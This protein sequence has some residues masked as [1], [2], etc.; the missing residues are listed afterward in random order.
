MGAAIR[1]G[2][3]L[4]GANLISENRP[5]LRAPKLTV[6][7]DVSLEDG[8]TISGAVDLSSATV[9]GHLMLKYHVD[10]EHELSISDAHVQTLQLEILPAEHVKV[11]LTGAVVT[12]LLDPK[13][14]G[15]RSSSWIGCTPPSC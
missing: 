15:P 9:D 4:D 14:R 3:E 13:S 10:G 7:G 6:T 1:A 2:L 5:A 11:N 8:A 12:S